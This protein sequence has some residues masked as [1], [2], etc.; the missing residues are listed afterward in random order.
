MSG[1]YQLEIVAKESEN[2][3]PKKDEEKLVLISRRLD[4]YNGLFSGV[5][6]KTLRELQLIQNAAASL[7][8]ETHKVL[9]KSSDFYSGFQ[10]V[11]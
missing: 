7:L 1:C 6:I 2:S 3:S 8:T 4:Y 5:S 9:I 10:S 11:I